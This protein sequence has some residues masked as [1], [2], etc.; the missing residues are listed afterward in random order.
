[1]ASSS[2]KAQGKA[3]ARGESGVTF[4]VEGRVCGREAE[5]EAGFQ[6]ALGLI[7]GWARLKEAGRRE[8][9][10]LSQPNTQR[11]SSGSG[12]RMHGQDRKGA[13]VR[14]CVSID[15]TA[16]VRRAQQSSLSWP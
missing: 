2:Q 7:L 1:M 3:R 4:A 15:P 10:T 8:K 14:V 6:T 12:S 16:K 13:C 11:L 5:K 9:A